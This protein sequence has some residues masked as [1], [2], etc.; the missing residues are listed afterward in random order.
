MLADQIPVFL[1]NAQA[2]LL[3]NG[4]AFPA[5]QDWLS[6][7]CI[8]DRAAAATQLLCTHFG[9]TAIVFSGIAGGATNTIIAFIFALYILL[10]KEKFTHQLIVLGQAFLPQRACNALAHVGKVA[11]RTFAKFVDVY[12]RQGGGRGAHCGKEQRAVRHSARHERQRRR[13]RI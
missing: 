13:K 2:W 6:E 1:K 10:G 12:K 5:L 8:R 7:M 11:A 3:A 4:D 9:A